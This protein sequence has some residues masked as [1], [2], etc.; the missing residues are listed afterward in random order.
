M[1][2]EV[3]KRVGSR[4]YRY[5]VESYR[6]PDTKKVRSRW[7]YLGRLVAD[8]LPGGAEAAPA[9]VLRR[10]PLATR[11]RLVDA[12]ERLAG[13]LPYGEISAGAVA[14]EAGL[15]HGTFY[16][17]FADKRSLFSAALERVRAE[18]DRVIPSFA[19]PDGTLAEERARV[20]A[21]VEAILLRVPG[22]AGV[23]RALFE[24]LENDA[25]LRAERAARRA[26]RVA[27][28]SGYLTRLSASGTIALERPEPLAEALLALGDAVLRT[29]VID[30]TVVDAKLAAGVVAVFDRAIFEVGV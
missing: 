19:P 9:P 13:R 14:K 17:H 7:T 11:E 2:H 18:L 20:R 23:L 12:F 10:A 25:E 21:W 24:A 30:R 28:F 1:P 8:G 16:R 26:E 15:A 6:D 4:A 27:A 3:I 22:R 5:R 29:A